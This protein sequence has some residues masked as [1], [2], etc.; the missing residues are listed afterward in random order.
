MFPCAGYVGMIGEGIRQITGLQKGFVLRNVTISAA[1]VLTEDST[2]EMVTNFRPV[3]LTDSLDSEWWEFSISSHNGNA[4]QK[5]FAGEAHVLNDET[6]PTVSSKIHQLP[7]MLDTRKYYDTFS[8][9]GMGYGPCFQLLENITAG[10]MDFD[11]AGQVL[12]SSCGDEKHYYIHPTVLDAA[13]QTSPLAATKGRIDQKQYR[14]VPTKIEKMTVYRCAP[15]ACMDVQTHSRPIKGSGDV[16]SDIRCSVNGKVLLD[17]ENITSSVLQEAETLEADKPL[18]TARLTWRP[19]IDFMNVKDLV[20]PA[21]SG[22]S[23]HATLNELLSLCLVFSHRRASQTDTNSGHLIMYKDWIQREVQSFG[24]DPLVAMDDETLE[25][26]IDNPVQSLVGT[27]V[28]ACAASLQKIQSN[29]EELVSGQKDVSD[30]LRVDGTSEALSSMMNSVDQS[31]FIRHLAHTKPNLRILEVGG[32]TG[33]STAAL[34]KY[35]VLPTGQ[36]LFSKYIFT[37]VSSDSFATVKN[38][39]KNYQN[40]DYRVL[41]TGKDPVDQGFG[42]DEKYDLVIANNALHLTKDLG[43]TLRFVSQLVRPGGRLLLH[44]LNSSFKWPNYLFGLLPSWWLAEDDGRID[45]PYVKPTRW[46]HELSRAGFAE[47]EVSIQDAPEPHQLNSFIIAK[48]APKSKLQTPGASVSILCDEEQSGFYVISQAL[49]A[50]GLRSQSFKLD[51]IT[52]LPEGQDIISLLDISKPFLQDIDE[53]S[54]RAFQVLIERLGN[55]QSGLFWVTKPSQVSCEDPNYA[56]II[57]AARTIRNEAL[58]DFATCEVDDFTS[59]AD[60]VVQVFAKFQ[61]EKSMEEESLDPEYD[62][63]ISEGVVKISRIYPFS[64]TD[65]LQSEI[66]QEER[67]ALDMGQVGR[68]NTLH[69]VSKEEVTLEGDDVEV[70]IHAAG[71][72]FKDILCSVAVLEFPEQGLGVESSGVVCRVG[73]GVKDLRVGDRVMMTKNGSFA[74]HTVASERICVKIP[75]R[76]SFEDAASMPA[77]YGTAVYGLLHLGALKKGQV[78]IS[79]SP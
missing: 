38:R 60:K 57:G 15:D 56:Q 31:Q 4:W 19:H 16:L 49:E 45:E 76:L 67:V 68:L 11:V 41:D 22:E 66:G 25:A 27:P 1:L 37:D 43:E 9:V 55:M 21:Y 75:D 26:K 28:E 7:R 61:S 65:E 70:Q 33:A 54:F 71:L 42:D 47:V 2:A 5:N 52:D 69:W 32:G 53:V 20:K 59:S 44:E 17:I 78:S 79:V 13:L 63:S 62:Y 40:I 12:R 24:T 39:F 8:R 46:E 51:E 18:S 6:E 73:P 3:R 36:P 58:V 34:V 77:V 74:S 48:M 23:Y 64:L 10:T 72:N 35:L 50:H 30:L 14:R 29:I